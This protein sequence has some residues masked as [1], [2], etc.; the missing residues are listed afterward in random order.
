M[1]YRQEDLRSFVIPPDFD[2]AFVNLGLGAL[3]S[4]TKQDFPASHAQWMSQNTNVTSVFD[5][6]KKY[7]YRPMSSNDAVNIIDARTYFCLRHFLE[8]AVKNKDEIALIPTWVNVFWLSLI[9][10]FY[11]SGELNRSENKSF[12]KSYTS[13]VLAGVL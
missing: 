8:D 11:S 6:L 4:E 3:L 5:A 1:F 10:S 12:C 13:S 2:D 9:H 7:A